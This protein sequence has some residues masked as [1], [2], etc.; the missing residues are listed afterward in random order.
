MLRFLAV[1]ILWL[2]LQGCALAGEA[3]S[4]EVQEGESVEALARFYGLTAESLARANPNVDLKTLE[5]G[6]ILQIP[7]ASSWPRHQ[8]EP[9]QTLWS[10]SKL[11]QVRLES[12]RQ[13]NARDSDRLQ[14]GEELLIPRHGF[15][16]L[17]TGG[18]LEVTLPDGRKAWAPVESI[19]APAGRPLTPPEL[20]ALA[21]RLVG[22]PYRWGGVSPNGVDCSGFVQEV[23]RLGGYELRRTAD[24]QF[25]DCLEVPRDQM[26]TGDLLFFST[27]EPGP[28]HVG[29]CTGPGR[30]LHASSSRGVVESS[31]EESYFAE[32]FLGVRR[33]REWQAPA[34]PED[35]QAQLSD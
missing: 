7:R 12:L 29:I 24:L 15:A 19:L 33:I 28:S 3:V 18:W 20:V 35:S 32:R 2:A 6:L 14:V 21:R 8:V 25:A 17:P 16:T 5:P 9:G 22:T 30:F 11:Y 1:T 10:I 34:P 13:A 23:F 31:L 4:H 26:Q 27:Y